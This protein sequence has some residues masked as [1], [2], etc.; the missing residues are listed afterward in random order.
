MTG[1]NDADAVVAV[2]PADCARR[3]RFAHFPS[4]LTVGHRFTVGNLQE[5]LPDRD[6]ERRAGKDQR[7]GELPQRAREIAIQFVGETLQVRMLAGHGSICEVPAQRAELRFQPAAVVELQ[8]AD[9][10][11]RRSG[12]E[13]SQR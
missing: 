11:I 13:L 7:H 4:E 12:E 8:K 2:A 6:L 5:A 1:N 3:G 10:F 9:A